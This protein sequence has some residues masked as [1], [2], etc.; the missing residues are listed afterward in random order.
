MANGK[1]K[2]LSELLSGDEIMLISKSGDT[3]SATI[4]RLK[5]ET[6]PFLRITWQNDYQ[7]S[8]SIPTTGRDSAFL[9]V[10]GRQFPVT[11]LKTGDSIL[12]HNSNHTR[13][14]GNK[15][16]ITSKEVEMAVIGTGKAHGA[17]SL[18]HAA[19]TGYGAAIAL[20][21]PVM[22][23]ALDKPSKRQLNDEDNLLTSVVDTW[24]ENNLIL[25]DGLEPR[26]IHWAVA[27]KDTSK[28]RVKNQVRQYQL[29]QS[30]HCVMR[31]IQN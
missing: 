12:C 7:I 23:K 26:D 27:S 11:K 19:G 9:Q 1:T 28:Q 25:P 8:N 6:R 13:H 24:I 5:I 2:Y 17:C 21:L 14:I 30:G 4:G 16:A 29:P 3:R 22:V 15:V 18:L 31:L 10:Q 20:D